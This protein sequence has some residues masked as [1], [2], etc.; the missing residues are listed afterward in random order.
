VVVI[1]DRG[2]ALMSRLERAL[3]RRD[4]EMNPAAPQPEEPSS[5]SAHEGDPHI[6]PIGVIEHFPIDRDGSEEKHRSPDEKRP[7]PIVPIRETRF[8]P[9]PPAQAPELVSTGVSKSF[10]ATTV[11]KVVG[12]AA[13]D[14]RSAEQYRRLAATLH[15]AQVERGINKV[16]V[17]S[18]VAGEGKTLTALNLAVT[19]SESY[20]RRV[21]LVDADLRCP[22][23]HELVDAAPTH[24]LNEALKAAH[25]KPLTLMTLSSRLSILPAGQADPDPM[26]QLTGTRMAAVL[27][28]LSEKFDWVILDTSPVVLL[29]DANLLAG[30]VD[31]AVIVIRA[32][33]TSY[34]LVDRA[35][36]TLGRK[37]V[38]GLILNQVEDKVSQYPASAYYRS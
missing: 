33:H 3:R 17:A 29:P 15:Q 11:G 26:G 1:L 31:G 36:Q 28:E 19:L 30:M 8:R 37:R 23:I 9:V 25:P 32:G 12:G 21:V 35:I 13:M 7:S 24:G 6:I 22:R 2:E 5:G 27:A 34:D 10:S 16:M 4:R 20:L 38:L 18:A 14:P